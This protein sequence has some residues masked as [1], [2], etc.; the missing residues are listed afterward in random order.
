MAP[1][2]S[3]PKTRHLTLLVRDER[4]WSNLCRIITLAHA[5]TRERAGAARAHGAVGGRAGGARPRRGARV[6]DGL[7]RALAARPAAAR[8]R[9]H[10]AGGCWRRSARRACTWSC[11]ARTPATI[12][13]ATER[14]SAH[15]RRLGVRCVAT[16][17]VHAHARARAELQDA[18]VALRH[19]AALDAC[20]PLRRGNHSHVLSTPRAMASRFA[21]HPQ[22]GP[23]DAGAGRAA[24]VRPDARTSA[25][26][27]RGPRTRTPRAA[28]LSCAGRGWT[29]AT[30][31][32]ACIRAR[33][34]VGAYAEAQARLEE[35]LRVIERLG[36]AGF[37][38]LHHDMLE[39]A[40]EVAAEVRGPE[41]GARAAGA[42][43]RAGLVGVLDRVLPDGALAHR[44][45]R[46]QAGAGALPARGPERAAGHRPG[47]PARHPRAADPARARALRARSR[48]AGGGLPD[49]PRA[50]GDP[51]A[52][53]GAGPAGRRDR[54]RGARRGPVGQRL[55]P[56]GARCGGTWRGVAR[57]R[58]C[59]VGIGGGLD[60][61]ALARAPGRAGVRAAAPSLP[62]PGRDGDR[63]EAADR[64]LP[65]GAGGD[66]GQADGAVGQGLVRGRGL[67]E[68]RPAGPGDALGG[69]A[70]RGGNRARA[71]GAHRPVAHPVRR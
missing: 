36:L 40:R 52:G 34:R 11:S 67:S 59:A 7:R 30:G 53:Q 49:V 55:L 47:L 19:H 69:G 16:G 63:D 32:T 50:R 8:G 12:A 21:D 39:L 25:T 64:L 15:A 56:G 35:E 68:D 26:A 62:A 38:L 48:G 13:P 42:G 41:L 5:H 43:T 60:A 31:R 4:G 9:A 57:S 44:P 24:D 3:R 17:N 20:E 14:S 10:G 45:D 1:G 37:F 6:P 22:S 71:R 29:S 70:L 61:L 46:G 54:A 51:R 27:I 33:V 28:W 65:G 18:F 66:G 58:R 2:A 23:R